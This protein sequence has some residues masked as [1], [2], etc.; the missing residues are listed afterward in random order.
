MPVSTWAGNSTGASFCR[1]AGHET[2]FDAARL[3]E[4]YP[5]HA[6]YE[7]K[8]A[9]D[10]AKLVKERWIVKQDGDELIAEAKRQFQTEGAASGGN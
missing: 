8:V 10:V 3:K 4:L 2:P 9:D 1:I 7:R 5:D 6:A